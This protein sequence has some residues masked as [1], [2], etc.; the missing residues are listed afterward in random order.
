ML[1]HVRGAAFIAVH[2]MLDGI[3]GRALGRTD[4]LAERVVDLGLPVNM[5]TEAVAR[6]ASAAS[7]EPRFI[8]A[9]A[10]INVVIGGID[11][12]RKPIKVAVTKI[13]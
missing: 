2:K 12:V 13:G 11:A 4:T 3:V 5:T 10:A 8:Q 1:W 9:A 7:P 6:N